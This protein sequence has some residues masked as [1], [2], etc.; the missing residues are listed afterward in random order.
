MIQ[1][2]M[3]NII[4][5]SI[6]SADFGNL[7]RDIEMINSSDAD[8][9]HL[10]IMD[11]VFVPNIS[12]GFPV[13]ESIKNDCKKVLDAHLMVVDPTPFIEGFKR[14]GI[15][16]FTVHYE[17]CT[18]LHRTIEQ[19]KEAGMKAGVAINP[20]TPVCLLEDIINDLDITLVMAVNPGFGGQKFIEN[21]TLKVSQLRE[22][23]ERKGSKSLIEVDGGINYDTGKRVIEAGA[24]AIISGNFI[25]KSADPCETIAK[26][27]QL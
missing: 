26:L 11:G 22:M 10:D 5:P 16:Y 18:H 17:A 24:D 15:T 6:L 25:F 19:I 20:H 1:K 8:W 21:T 27:K 14:L 2:T 12:Y 7:R 3:G 23:I 4:S 9:I 13:L